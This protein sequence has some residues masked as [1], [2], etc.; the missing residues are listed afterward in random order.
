MAM[1]GRHGSNRN[2]PTPASMSSATYSS[3]SNHFASFHNPSSLSSDVSR[4]TSQQASVPQHTRP[5]TLTPNQRVPQVANSVMMSSTPSE[6]FASAQPHGP[7][8][9]SVSS[10]AS[11][12]MGPPVVRSGTK[13]D[14]DQ[15]LFSSTAP[16]QPLAS[17]NVAAG[18]M[19]DMAA[20]TNLAPMTMDMAAPSPDVLHELPDPQSSRA[21]Q[22]RHS[23]LSFDNSL[24]NVMR[25]VSGDIEGNDEAFRG[26]EVESNSSETT[27]EHLNSELNSIYFGKFAIKTG[28]PDCRSDLEK[29]IAFVPSAVHDGRKSVTEYLKK[30]WGLGDANMV[31]KLNAGSR[32]PKSLVNSMLSETEGFS[33]WKKD[34]LLQVQRKEKLV[35]KRIWKPRIRAACGAKIGH[36]LHHT[37]TNVVRANRTVDNFKDGLK[38][39]PDQV[40]PQPTPKLRKQL[41][42]SMSFKSGS[43]VSDDAPHEAR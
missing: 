22:G 10:S 2:P 40:Y 33:K 36:S 26:E 13:R 16:Q 39:E 6:P 8:D 35:K 30:I 41:S 18:P 29:D 25:R 11:I 17:L 28:F 1:S 9:V 14:A 7:D 37:A 3:A 4:R 21:H 27:T 12:T 23:S 34:A 5:E 42:K 19:H 32:H 15:L 38:L 24:D 31:L 20:A 43:F